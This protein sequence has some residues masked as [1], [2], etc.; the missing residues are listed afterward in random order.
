M[1]ATPMLTGNVTDASGVWIAREAGC[2]CA[3]RS[4]LLHVTVGVRAASAHARI[5]TALVLAGHIAGAVRVDHALGP[6]VRR[7]ANVVGHARADRALVDDA[8]V[9]IAAAR[10]RHAR[11]GGFVGFDDSCVAS[12]GIDAGD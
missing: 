2:A 9:R 8:T 12:G 3:T 10:R 1:P 6:T 5:D 7:S 11:I 4:M